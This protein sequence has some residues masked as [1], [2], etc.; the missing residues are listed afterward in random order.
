MFNSSL[1]A[2]VNRNELEQCHCFKKCTKKW[3]KS[4]C[5][6]VYKKLK[7]CKN[8]NGSV[9]RVPVIKHQTHTNVGRDKMLE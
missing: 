8:T 6:Y 4:N 7:G 5:C 1:S 9:L 2:K 3:A